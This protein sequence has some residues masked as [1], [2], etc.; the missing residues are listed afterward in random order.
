MKPDFTKKPNFNK[1]ILRAIRDHKDIVERIMSPM[2]NKLITSIEHASKT[3]YSAFKNGK[4]V[5][6]FGNGGS[7]ADAEHI[8][9]ELL[10]RFRTERVPLPAIALTTNAAVLTAIANDYTFE[11]VYKRQV[12]ALANVGDVVIGI[13][14]SG[15]SPNVLNALVL[16]HNKSAITIGMTGHINPD[17]VHPFRILKP[18]IHI[19]V[20]AMPTARVQ[21]MHIMIGHIICQLI[22]HQLVEEAK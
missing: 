21:E 9:G 17:I 19:E 15:S 5:L 13:T 12:G 4:K 7:A 2:G 14:T 11:N 10:G 16:A 22:E 1:Q 3:I 18:D 8:A 6:L 20:P